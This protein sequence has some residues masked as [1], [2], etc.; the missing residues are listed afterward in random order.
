MNPLISAIAAAITEAK[1]VNLVEKKVLTVEQIMKLERFMEHGSRFEVLFLGCFLVEGRVRD[2][3]DNV[4]EE[5]PWRG[6]RRVVLDAPP[7]LGSRL[8]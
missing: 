4:E 2:A 3:V 8:G 7:P 5:R 1:T 6:C